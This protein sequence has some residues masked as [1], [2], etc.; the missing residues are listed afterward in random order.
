MKK[1]DCILLKNMLPV[2]LIVN[3]AKKAELQDIPN[4]ILAFNIKDIDFTDLLLDRSNRNNIIEYKLGPCYHRNKGPAIIYLD[5]IRQWFRKGKLH[6]YDGPAIIRNIDPNEKC[7]YDDYHVVS[8]TQKNIFEGWY[9]QG[10]LHR[11]GGPAVIYH[12]GK[13]EWYQHGKLHRLGE[14]AVIFPDGNELWYQHG[15][16][17]RMDG[18]AVILD[19]T[20]LWY[21]RG[22]LHRFG[23]PASIHSNGKEVWYQYGELHREDGPAIRYP[24]GEIRWYRR[25]R[26]H[27]ED[28]PAVILPSGIEIWYRNNKMLMYKEK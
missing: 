16:L 8:E 4:I 23:G 27:R 28:G 13:K 26:L 17:H 9:D 24:D 15:K 3:I 21:Q 25:G 5:K 7:L 6:R 12:D 1:I 14:P 18:P 19:G 11:F 2:E 10:L 22:Q 20:R